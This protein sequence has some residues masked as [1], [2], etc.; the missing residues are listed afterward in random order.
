L[1]LL[2]HDYGNYPFTRQLARELAARGHA[3]DYVYSESTQL[4]QRGGSDGGSGNLKITGI[5]LER[6]FEKYNY[7]RRR[8]C[9]IEHGQKLAAM[10]EQSHPDVVLSANT[11]LDAQNLALQSSRKAGAKLIF[12]MQ[13]AIGLATKQTLA[14]KIPILGVLVGD[15]YA[16]LERDMLRCSDQVVL[17]SEDFLPLMKSWQVDESRCTV[18]PNWAPLDELPVQPKGNAWAMTHNLADKFCFIYTGILGLKHNPALFIQLTEAFKDNTE[19][20]VVVI[21]AGGAADR[22]VREA[23]RRELNNLLVLPPQPVDAYA[24]VLGAA[25]VLTAVLSEEAGRYSAPSKVLS[26]LCAAR[27][28]LLAV[29]QGNM[30]ARIVLDCQAGLVS[31]PT[32]S[33]R[34]VENARILY[35]NHTLAARMGRNARAC[36]E[37]QFDIKTIIDRFEQVFAK[38][39]PKAV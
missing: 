3:V 34:W 29:P 6:P 21:S 23:A 11:P 22:L 4:I 24:Q 19:V 35:D 5:R 33:T 37:K 26:Y 7:L 9:E 31:S 18:I 30:S 25:D 14:L 39:C 38:A 8:A 20:R 10:I 28:L 32:E 2:L 27:P 15:Y 12:W 1:K 13:D 36:A 16:T 17:I